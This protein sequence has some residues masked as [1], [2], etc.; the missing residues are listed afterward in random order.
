MSLRCASRAV[1][2]HTRSLLNEDDRVSVSDSSKGDIK[3]F[4]DDA[5]PLTQ[6]AFRGNRPHARCPAASAA[7]PSSPAGG[8]HPVSST[9]RS[10]PNGK[11]Q[12]SAAA[13]AHGAPE[14]KAE[15]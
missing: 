9:D 12:H 10:A 1:S 3:R 14:A 7:C 5:N 4:G 11:F 15:K 13:S 6:R 2:T 8:C